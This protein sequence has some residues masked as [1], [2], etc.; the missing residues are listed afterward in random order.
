MNIV[1]HFLI[2]QVKNIKLTKT[3]VKKRIAENCK[4]G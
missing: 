1:N 3:I 2:I 4:S